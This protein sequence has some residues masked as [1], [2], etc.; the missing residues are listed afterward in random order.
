MITSHYNYPS[1]D[2]LKPEKCINFLH[3]SLKTLLTG[4]FIGQEMQVKFA[5]IGQAMMQAARPKFLLALLQVGLGVQLHHLHA[6]H[7][8]IDSYFIQTWFLLLLQW[9]SS[10]WTKCS[11]ELYIYGTTIPN[12]LRQ[13]VQY[14]ADNVN[15][16]IRTLDGNNTFHSMRMITTVTPACKPEK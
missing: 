2:E 16:N 4:W 14:V 15:H 1:F 5:L 7:F 9:S 11:V 10:I 8:L 3:V 13:F 12:H 6:S